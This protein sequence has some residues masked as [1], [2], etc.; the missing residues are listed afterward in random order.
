[1]W[2]SI[3]S[4]EIL[5]HGDPDVLASW[6]SVPPAA[7]DYPELLAQAED[8]LARREQAYPEWVR[9]GRMGSDMASA[10][11]AA[12]R[13]IVAEWRWI[14]RGPEA[15]GADLPAPGTLPARRAAIELSL[16]RI[17]A[18]AHRRR[19]PDLTA[20]AERLDALR[21]H[22]SRVGEGAFA[23]EPKVHR[24]ARLSRQLRAES[25]LK[26]REAA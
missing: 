15:A 19:T 24:F 16:E 8:S 7:F 18:E 20:Q 6:P 26:E 9:A 10:D 21:W 23:D 5:I 13:L 11:I 3:M 14:V 2:C 22:L 17:E 4:G 25:L 1:M 12:W